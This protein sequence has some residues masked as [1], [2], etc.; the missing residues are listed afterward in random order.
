MV[1]IILKMDNLNTLS[2]D[3]TLEVLEISKSAGKEE[4][5]KSYRKV[6]S[7]PEKVDARNS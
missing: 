6:K 5:R 7:V 2:T 4:V 1:N 3:T